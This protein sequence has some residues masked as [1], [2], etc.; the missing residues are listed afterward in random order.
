MKY[1]VVGIGNMGADYDG[2]RH[3]IGFDVVDL[4][5]REGEATFKDSY[6]G[7][8]AEIKYKGRKI[9]LLKPS[10]YVNLSG[11]AVRYWLQKEKVQLKNLLIVTDDM[12]LPFGKLRIRGKGSDGGHNGLKDINQYLGSNYARLRLGIG[13]APQGRHVDFVLGKWDRN[14][15]AELPAFLSK[16][17]ETVRSFASI[18]L[19]HTMNEFNAE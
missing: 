2:T 6:L 1:L 3:N 17:A 7:D 12:N 16:A 9:I 10:T 14:E 13:S 5:A 8:I 15:M 18:G 4:L 19:T 11:K